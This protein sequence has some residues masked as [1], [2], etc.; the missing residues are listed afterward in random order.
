MP[1]SS[2]R[3]SPSPPTPAVPHPSCTCP[4]LQAIEFGLPE[5]AF[6]IYR[7]F[8]RKVEAI[9]VRLRVA[10]AAQGQRAAA[11]PA[12]TVKPWSNPAWEVPVNP[13][14]TCQAAG[15]LTLL[16]ALLTAWFRRCA[17][18]C[19]SFYDGQVQARLASLAHCCQHPCPR[20]AP[21][22]HTHT[23][24]PHLTPLPGAHQARGRPGPRPR[25]CQQGALH[26]RATRLPL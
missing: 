7:K 8:G 17:V 1:R 10:T 20:Q 25:L 22:A 12:S 11:P 3:F 19:M 6:E 14:W 18:M 26:C 16:R 13:A 9:Q 23:R 4:L 21:H 2:T 5:E 15:H 24:T